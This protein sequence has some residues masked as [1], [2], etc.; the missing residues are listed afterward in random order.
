M[1]IDAIS[2][3]ILKKKTMKFLL[4]WACKE[5]KKATFMLDDPIASK[6]DAF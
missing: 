6:L 4:K 2:M 5:K 1:R 3:Q